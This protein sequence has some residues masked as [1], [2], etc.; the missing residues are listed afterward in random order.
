MQYQELLTEFKKVQQ[1]VEEENTSQIL[2]EKEE[3]IKIDAFISKPRDKPPP[4]RKS[5][6]LDKPIEPKKEVDH[7]RTP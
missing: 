3:N 5:I 1:F 7:E 2:P 4:R 6:L